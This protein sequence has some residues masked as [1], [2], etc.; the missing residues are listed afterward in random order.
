MQIPHTSVLNVGN[1]LSTP[2]AKD[3][4]F[5]FSNM[6]SEN[7][8]Y[9]DLITAELLFWIHMSEQLHS[10]KSFFYPYLNCLSHPPPN[11]YYWPSPILHCLKGTNLEILNGTQTL[12][13]DQSNMLLSLIPQLTCFPADKLRKIFSY[14]SLAWAKGHYHSR[15]YFN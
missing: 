13:K 5:I 7:D 10:E 2:L 6:T 15:G 8:E 12:L 14:E 3:I 9:L 1:A 11:P 4:L